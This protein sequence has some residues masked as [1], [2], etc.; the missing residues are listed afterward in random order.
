MILEY[1]L[2][3]THLLQT[4]GQKLKK[5][6]ALQTGVV[7]TRVVLLDMWCE[8]DLSRILGSDTAKRLLLDCWSP[9]AEEV[10][11]DTLV[12]FEPRWSR[13]VK[14]DWCRRCFR[15]RDSLRGRRYWTPQIGRIHHWIANQVLIHVR[16]IGKEDKTGAWW[17]VD[18][19]RSAK[20]PAWR[21]HSWSK[22]F[23]P[24]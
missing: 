10:T 12:T 8:N 19:R 1:S 21:I 15:R 11:S 5:M 2:H 7:Q 9:N 18:S 3:P 17:A 6:P 13:L 14:L 24:V 20:N 22:N 16:I 23:N 4:K